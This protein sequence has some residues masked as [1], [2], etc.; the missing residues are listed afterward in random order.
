M[1][2]RIRGW[3][4]GLESPFKADIYFI[5]TRLF[6]GIK[7]GTS[8]PVLLRDE[9]FGVVRV[10][11]FGVYDF[12]IVDPPKF[13][14]EVAGTD[15]HFQLGEFVDAMRSRI[16]SVFSEALACSKVP[17]LDIATRHSELGGAL[18]PLINPALREKYGIESTS[19]LVENVSV[20]PD[21]EQAID[22][23]SSISVI[24]NLNDYVKYQMAQGMERHGSGLGAMAA[25]MTVG[26]SIAQMILNQSTNATQPTPAPVSQPEVIPDTIGPAEAAAILCVSEADVIMSLEAGDL[27]GRQVGTQWRIPKLA[28]ADFLQ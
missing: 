10:R 18:L 19:F 11:S 8:N 16:V 12:R 3:K 5:T 17:V 21:V 9:D 1:L 2:S 7:W 26:M 20:P 24:G 27:K 6:T 14:T 4:Y 28:I 23:R 15:G 22:K 13:L 25:E